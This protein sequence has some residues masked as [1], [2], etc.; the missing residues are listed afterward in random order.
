MGFPIFRVSLVALAFQLV[1][2]MLLA[3]MSVAC[4]VWLAVIVEGLMLMGTSVC[5]IVTEAARSVV[6]DAEAE[7]DD[8]THMIKKLRERAAAMV[9][10]QE[11]ALAK[12]EVEKLAQ[13]LRYA[14]PISSEA[15]KGLESKIEYLLAQ[16]GEG[17]THERI[18]KAKRALALIQ[19]RSVV[20]KSSK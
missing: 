8:K 13:A 9:P 14:D 16:L 10:L 17:A 20:A 5:L 1:V 7:L 19:Q 4:P 3:T 12:A 15:T 2:F 18:E 11:D 6:G